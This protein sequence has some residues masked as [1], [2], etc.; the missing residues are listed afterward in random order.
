MKIDNLLKP[1]IICMSI[2][3]LY[4]TY[5]MVIVSPVYTEYKKIK[6]IDGD[7]FAIDNVYYRLMYI[8]TAEKGEP[9]YVAS[10]KF[11]CDYLKTKDFKLEING[12][13]KYNREL[14]YV[15]TQEDSLN[16]LLI[17]K[18]LAKPFYG[19][20]AYWIERLYN[21]CIVY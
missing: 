13:D 17:Q 9:T 7:T 10:S 14:V 19:K 5:Q 15:Y 18:C 3:L 4:I 11:T 16:K 8:D 21:N 12:K 20:T 1:A 6:C 2:I